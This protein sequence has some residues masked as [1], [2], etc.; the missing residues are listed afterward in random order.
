MDLVSVMSLSPRKDRS[1][2][3]VGHAGEVALS[4]ED[5]AQGAAVEI[6]DV[7]GAGEVSDEHPA[8]GH[9]EGEADGL[10]QVPD[11]DLRLGLPVDGRAVDGVAVRWVAAIGPVEDAVLVI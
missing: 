9:V 7:D 11:Q 3:G 10:H 8:A 4:A 1:D 5:G 2:F 6:G